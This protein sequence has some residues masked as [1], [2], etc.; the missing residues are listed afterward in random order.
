MFSKI[1]IKYILIDHIKTLRSHRT[2]KFSIGDIALFLGIPLMLSSFLSFGSHIRLDVNFIN[3]LVT[4]LSVFS[5]LLFNLLLLIYDILRK[6]NKESLGAETR[7]QFLKEIYANI[8]FS[9]LISVVTIVFLLILFFD[10]KIE[11]LIDII[12]AIVYFLVIN[13]ILT[14]LMVLKRVHILLSQEMKE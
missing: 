14:I 6:D 8:S 7:R 9:I 2:G 10:L 11:W 4:S 1:N 5:A 3:A 12:N 13:F